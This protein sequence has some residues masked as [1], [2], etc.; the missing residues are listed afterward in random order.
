MNEHKHSRHSPEADK[1]NWEWEPLEQ[2]FVELF[3][4]AFPRHGDG[5]LSR[6]GQF[7]RGVMERAIPDPA[8]PAD[9]SG[10]TKQPLFQ[11]EVSETERFVK[12]SIRIPE[13]I[14]PRKLQLFVNGLVLKIDGPLG[15]TQSIGLPAPVGTKSM[16]AIYRN[17]TLHIRLHKKTAPGYKELHIQYP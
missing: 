11:P 2:L 9:L 15:H 5:S 1:R 8:Q 17:E 14:D 3:P 10:E 7:V 4:N 13:F 12:V 16:Q 6:I